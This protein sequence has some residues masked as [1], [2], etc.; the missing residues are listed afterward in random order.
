MHV[1]EDPARSLGSSWCGQPNSPCVGCCLGAGSRV[2][3]R[4]AGIGACFSVQPPM[5]TDLRAAKRPE[6]HLLDAM[7]TGQHQGGQRRGS[8]RRGHCVALLVDVDLPVP[9]APGLGGRKHAP[10]TAHVAEGSLPSP[11][12]ASARHTG[13]TGHSPPSSPGL[14]A[15]LHAGLKLHSI[16]L[17]LV[18]GNACVHRPDDVGPDGG[19]EHGWEG[20]LLAT[21]GILVRGLDG[22]QGPGSGHGRSSP[23]L[24]STDQLLN[25]AG[26]DLW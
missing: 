14:C 8:Q 17:A 2:I 23:L 15:A 13:D 9:P 26:C 22:H 19:S 21:L 16:G 4:E 25:S 12:R 24:G 7:P 1:Q 3:P 18:L 10:A 5:C 20:G 6:T 11:V